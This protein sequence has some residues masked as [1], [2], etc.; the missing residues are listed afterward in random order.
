M[1]E[2]PHEVTLRLLRETRAEMVARFD[3]I[4]HRLHWIE[5]RLGAT[6]VADDVP[7]R[8]PVSDQAAL[9]YRDPGGRDRT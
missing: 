5:Q 7:P 6:P 3:G 1:D 4:D 8:E 9:T 2:E